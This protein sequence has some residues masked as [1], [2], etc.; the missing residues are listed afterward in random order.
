METCS[1]NHEVIAFAGSHWNQCP[2]CPI[3]AERDEA[4]TE[5]DKALDRVKELEDEL[6][7]VLK[8]D[9]E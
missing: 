8:E 7:Y 9:T 4:I 3:V 1:D 6:E 2:V 5:R